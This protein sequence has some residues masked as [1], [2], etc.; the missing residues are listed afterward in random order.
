M[1]I[2]EAS[3]HLL[4][5]ILK[6]R[7][8]FGRGSSRGAGGCGSGQRRIR[9]DGG[10]GYG[11]GRLAADGLDVIAV[12]GR[13][14]G[15]DQAARQGI[16]CPVSFAWSGLSVGTAGRARLPG[17][18]GPGPRRY[19]GARRCRPCPAD[20]LRPPRPGWR[21][22]SP[23]SKGEAVEPSGVA[24]VTRADAHAA[25]AGA[26]RGVD[27]RSGDHGHGGERR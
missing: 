16:R 15:P 12:A 23:A 14:G 2:R 22:A 9:A 21:A 18:A 8:R 4:G 20:W 3:T 19:R 17:R 27:L 1:S 26:G 6:G 7:R 10:P 25:A 13:G 5:R 11:G 24:A